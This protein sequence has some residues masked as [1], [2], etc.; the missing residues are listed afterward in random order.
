MMDGFNPL[1]LLASAAELQQ[2]HEDGPERIIITRQRRINAGKTFINTSGQKENRE[3]SNNNSS[4]NKPSVV[5]VKKIKKV[6]VNPDLEKMLDEH[7]YGN[8]KRNNNKIGLEPVL[9]IGERKR[10]GTMLDNCHTSEICVQAST[11]EG[12]NVDKVSQ[13]NDSEC[14]HVVKCNIDCTDKTTHSNRICICKQEN[15]ENKWSEFD[16]GTNLYSQGHASIVLDKNG[17]NTLNRNVKS[18]DILSRTPDKMKYDSKQHKIFDIS[19]GSRDLLTLSEDGLDLDE[20]TGEFITKPGSKFLNKHSVNEKGDNLE[21]CSETEKD[22]LLCLSKN[23]SCENKLA[24]KIRSANLVKA[25]SKTMSSHVPKKSASE[26]KNVPSVKVIPSD[27]IS[28]PVVDKQLQTFVINITE[29]NSSGDKLTKFTVSSS[30]NLP[31]SSIEGKTSSTGIIRSLLTENKVGEWNEGVNSGSKKKPVILNIVSPETKLQHCDP[32]NRGE[33]SASCESLKDL[34]ISDSLCTDDSST[35]VHLFS[36]DCRNPDS[37]GIV[38]SPV[39]HNVNELYSGDQEYNSVIKSSNAEEQ[40]ALLDRPDEIKMQ[41]GISICSAV[42]SSPLNSSICD[43]AGDLDTPSV[44]TIS[45]CRE[46]TVESG[47]LLTEKSENCDNSAND[48]LP[49]LS[50]G[51]G[52]PVFQF[53][54]DHCYAGM[55]GKINTERGSV[56]NENLVQSEEEEAESPLRSASELSQDSGYE[57]VTQSPEVQQPTTVMEENINEKPSAVKNLVPVLVSVNSNGCLT[58][59]DTNLTKTL[60]GQVFLHENMKLISGTNITSISQAPLILSPVA[61][62]KATSPLLTEV[63]KPVQSKPESIIG[64]LSP[65]TSVM[66]ATLKDSQEIS[67][68]KY[69]KFRIGTFASFSNTG[70]DLESPTKLSLQV[71]NEDKPKKICQASIRCRSNSVKG[72]KSSPVVDTL[73][74]LVQKVKSSLSPASYVEPNGID[75]IHHDHDYCTKN[76]MPSVVNSFLEARLLSKDSA[77]GKVAHSRGKKSDIDFRSEYKSSKRKRSSAGVTKEE[78]HDDYDVDSESDTLSNPESL[79][80][81]YRSEKLIEPKQTDPKVKITGS[82]NFQDQFVYFMN[83]KKRSR[84]RESKDIPLPNGTDRIFIPPKP[85]DIVVPHLTDQ[86]IENLK[87]R[88]KQSKH[89]PGTPCSN[90]LRNEFMAAKLGNGVFPATQPPETVDDEKNIINTILSL[91]NED[92]VSP[93]Q[94]EPPRYNESMELYGQGLNA[95]I[96]NLFPEQMNLT[97]EQMDILYSAV[98]E[99]QNSSPGLVGTEKLVS[100][101]TSN[102]AFQF[103]MQS[104]EDSGVACTTT[105]TDGCREAEDTLAKETQLEQD[106]C[107]DEANTESVSAKKDATSVTDNLEIA[108]TPEN[109]EILSDRSVD[110]KSNEKTGKSEKTEE[111][112]S[113]EDKSNANTIIPNEKKQL[114]TSNTLDN[115]SANSGTSPMS[116]QNIAL[117]SSDASNES[118]KLVNPVVP[119]TQI[120]AGKALFPSPTLD[121][122]SVATTFESDISSAASS[123]LT[124]EISLPQIDKSLY[125]L[126]NDFRL[127][128]GDLFPDG[129]VPSTVVQPPAQVDYNA[130]WIVTVS[131]YWND[132]PAIMINNQPFVRLVD[133]HKQIL[134][135]KDTGILKKRCQLMSIEV[136]NCSEMQRY[137][138][139]QYGRAFNSKSTLIISKDNAKILI[140]YYVDPQPKTT[141]PEDHHKS[142]IDHRREQLRRIALARRAAMRAQRLS[143]KKDEPDPREIKEPQ[144]DSDTDQPDH[145]SLQELTKKPEVPEVAPNLPHNPLSKIEGGCRQRATRHK[146]IN[147]LELLRGDTSSHISEEEPVDDHITKHKLHQ[148]ATDG[149]KKTTLKE[150]KVKVVKYTIETDSS[151]ETDSV[152][153]DY[154]SENYDTDSTVGSEVQV[155]KKPVKHKINPCFVAKVQS[156]MK[157][158]KSYSKGRL[159]VKLGL[160]QSKS[161]ATSTPVAIRV[162]NKQAAVTKFVTSAYRSKLSQ[163]PRKELPPK[164]PPGIL[165]KNVLSMKNSAKEDLN[166]TSKSDLKKVDVSENSPSA[167]ANM[168][169]N[170][171]SEMEMKSYRNI[172]SADEVAPY[173]E[174]PISP[175]LTEESSAT[176]NLSSSKTVETSQV[177][178]VESVNV[179]TDSC[180]FENDDDTNLDACNIDNTS[181]ENNTESKCLSKQANEIQECSSKSGG[182]EIESRSK[183]PALAESSVSVMKRKSNIQIGNDETPIRIIHQDSSPQAQHRSRSQLGELFVEHYHNKKSLCVRCYTCRKMMSVDNFLRHQHDISGGLLSVNLPR[184]IDLTEPELNENEG[185]HWETFLRKKELFDNNQLPSPDIVGDTLVYSIDGDSTDSSRDIRKFTNKS[186]QSGPRIITTPVSPIKREKIV[187][188]NKT[189][190]KTKSRLILNQTFSHGPVSKKQSTHTHVTEGVRTSSR[191]RKMKHLYG[192]EDYSFTKFPRLMKNAVVEDANDQVS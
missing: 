174:L 66:S 79:R 10:I 156:R 164:K 32:T 59:H 21:N 170:N 6:D 88:S 146:K 100:A 140:G 90:S 55:P 181:L 182:T 98:D 173:M 165:R 101:E 23:S 50:S 54:S 113:V 110:E 106:T 188:K 130:P 142:I 151:E 166:N 35:S 144:N 159:K 104:F 131:M 148:V 109:S 111:L 121:T 43:S 49:T 2:K 51:S 160:K 129:A 115:L 12:Q 91:E 185:K 149:K 87:L 1:D 155:L 157:V 71:K 28:E 138:L 77:K 168:K 62:G 191:K 39:T 27:I 180:S 97:P 96:M 120:S 132:L 85:G 119:T 93:V 126:G 18:H 103:P 136:E 14:I 34:V 38:E 75:H 29:G 9:E 22:E 56:E 26:Q 187:R 61:V 153:S 52:I 82:S 190:E 24:T 31:D 124:S 72:G 25:E 147:F 154:S 76:L 45:D 117:H 67:P 37:M 145:C 162:V 33:K 83:T 172:K 127:D 175:T 42:A 68:P 177:K 17:Q 161:A 69:G 4:K 65:K 178:L 183:S 125:L 152:Q 122:G 64:I 186:S 13:L 99:V 41:P 78:V 89:Q 163:K 135:A 92:L 48:I 74:T 189:V 86:D 40:L 179:Q 73:G 7:N 133:I 44:E 60:G 169:C 171:S 30:Q 107:A 118:I 84:R 11:T 141:R 57:D 105:V 58:V 150:R 128:K 158:S 114:E 19:V 20:Q 102:S 134:P 192:F 36:P 5:I 63:P 81:K 70:V 8:A 108:E 167:F 53:D 16:R 143:E 112:D 137:F 176:L 184:K 139:V 116:T 15:S 47:L 46:L 95:D 80:P 3:L 94:S 123:S